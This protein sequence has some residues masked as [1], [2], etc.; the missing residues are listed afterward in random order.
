MIYLPKNLATVAKFVA[1]ES[2]RFSIAGVRVSERPTLPLDGTRGYRVEATDGRT[3]VRV[4]GPSSAGWGSAGDLKSMLKNAPNG[5]TAATIP[6]TTFKAALKAAMKGKKGRKEAATAVVFGK[7]GATLANQDENGQPTFQAAPDNVAGRFPDTSCVIPGETQ[8]VAAVIRVDGDRLAEVLKAA[9]EFADNNS[10]VQAVTLELRRQTD[11]VV[12]RS[13]NEAGQS[14]TAV[15][16]P[17]DSKEM[18]QPS[19][20]EAKRLRD[21]IRNALE[22]D[23]SDAIKDLLMKLLNDAS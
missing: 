19:V 12:V 3:L 20:K 13:A 15:V 22:L 21:G 7:D 8:P 11:A 14:F 4:D 9:A 1:T 17:L 16:M 5:E 6:A 23:G 18:E 10:D 2:A